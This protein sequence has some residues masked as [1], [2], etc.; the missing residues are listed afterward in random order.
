MWN[1]H[2]SDPRSQKLSGKKL[3]GRRKL[4]LECLCVGVP[5]SAG[6]SFQRG[7]KTGLKNMCG[8][9]QNRHVGVCVSGL[10][11]FFS[12]FSTWMEKQNVG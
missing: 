1:L 12:L 5:G 7:K 3:C 10:F 6:S 11:V 8:K 4:I 2:N 9:L